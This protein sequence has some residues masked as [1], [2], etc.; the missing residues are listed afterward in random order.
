[1]STLQLRASLLRRT[2]FLSLPFELQ[3]QILGYHHIANAK[4]IIVSPYGLQQHQRSIA[5]LP[6]R[7]RLTRRQVGPGI[8]LQTSLWNVLDSSPKVCKAVMPILAVWTA[9]EIYGFIFARKISR[10]VPL[11]FVRS[12]RR[13]HYHESHGRAW[14]RWKGGDPLNV[15]YGLASQ[16]KGPRRFEI[17]L[18]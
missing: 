10:H 5:S 8:S 16:T 14:R 3:E 7:S 6:R 1:M 11:E 18:S 17:D 9:I 15:E 12:A 2:T 13:I 4:L